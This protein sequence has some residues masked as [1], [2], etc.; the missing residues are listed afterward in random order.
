MKLG[1]FADHPP[2][3]RAEVVKTASPPAYHVVTLSFTFVESRN[4]KV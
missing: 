2:A 3:F 4:I 1:R